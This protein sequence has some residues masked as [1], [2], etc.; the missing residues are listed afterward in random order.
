MCGGARDGARGQTLNSWSEEKMLAMLR[1]CPLSAYVI[2]RTR[3]TFPCGVSNPID[4]MGTAVTHK[5]Q[6]RRQDR[7]E[8][9][10]RHQCRPRHPTKQKYRRLVFSRVRLADCR[11]RHHSRYFPNSPDLPLP[12]HPDLVRVEVFPCIELDQP[13]ALQDL[14]AHVSISTM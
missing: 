13:Y 2:W 1:S 10:Q 9:D 11:N 5:R 3:H 12:Q 7:D 4:E 14:Y 6:Y 8:R